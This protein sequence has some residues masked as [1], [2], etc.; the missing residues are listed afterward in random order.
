ME[1]DI[2]TEGF[3]LSEKKYRLRYILAIGDGDSS[4]MATIHQSASY[5]VFVK[6]IEY[7]NHTCKAY[8]SRLKAVVKDNPRF[9]G[10]G[11]LTKKL[12]NVLP[13][14]QELQ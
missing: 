8:R 5:G 3:S 1:S 9:W 14:E 12:Y 2:V 10:K 6:K 4:V 13:S 7:T 11:G